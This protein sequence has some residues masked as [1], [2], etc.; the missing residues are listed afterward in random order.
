[1]FVQKYNKKNPSEIMLQQKPES[2]C[3]GEQPPGEQSSGF[4]ASRRPALCTA[5]NLE[6][7]CLY[8]YGENVVKSIT[9]LRG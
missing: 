1:M 6:C 9:I 2:R 4:A 5:H 7:L 3:N 8:T